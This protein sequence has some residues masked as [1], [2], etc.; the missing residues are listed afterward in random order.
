MRGGPMKKNISVPCF[1]ALLTLGTGIIFSQ[2]PNF[3][4]EWNLNFSKSELIPSF[5]TPKMTWLIRQEGVLLTIERRVRG[6]VKTR[7]YL[8]DGKEFLNV[9]S[10]VGDLKGTAEFVSGKLSVKTEEEVMTVTY[11]PEFPD[12][13]TWYSKINM[14]EEYSISEDGKTMSVTQIFETPNGESYSMKLVFD[15]IGG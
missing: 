3:S 4:G 10:G 6:E 9:S 1:V 11:S 12:G 8:I 13:N 7:R 2:V 14:V 5:S 15:K